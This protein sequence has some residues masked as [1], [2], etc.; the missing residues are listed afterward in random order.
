MAIAHSGRAGS[1]AGRRE[2]D[3]EGDGDAG[4]GEVGADGRVAPLQRED[5]PAAPG[6]IRAIVIARGGVG[7]QVLLVAGVAGE[8]LM[9][10]TWHERLP[11][12]ELET[13]TV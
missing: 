4:V 13:S 9:W 1:S 7:D 3:G 2:G 10:R 8:E 12:V 6:L 11:C 5:G